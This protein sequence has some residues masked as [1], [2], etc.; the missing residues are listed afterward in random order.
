MR[1]IFT[2]TRCDELRYDLS[3]AIVNGLCPKKLMEEKANHKKWV[4]KERLE[5]MK[6]RDKAV[7][8]HDHYCSII[9]N[10]ADQSAFG[11]PNFVAKTKTE[12]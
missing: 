7:L 1:A 2:S 3:N 5:Y 4:R 6:R 8:H 10:G 11:L 9:V 12:R